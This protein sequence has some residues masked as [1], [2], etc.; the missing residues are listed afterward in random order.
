MKRVMNEWAF[1]CGYPN[2]Q[3]K[4]AAHFADITQPYFIAHMI[5][6][7]HHVT[8]THIIHFFYFSSTYFTNVGITLI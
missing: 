5:L 3:S 1:F 4:G 7:F 2:L 6:N 8:A